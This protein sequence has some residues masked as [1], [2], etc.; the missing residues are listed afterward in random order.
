MAQPWAI[1]FYKS[2]AWRKCRTAYQI[3]KHHLCER[4]GDPG[5]EVHHRIPLTPENINNPEITLR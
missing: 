1:K 2:K 3:N 4:C 5:E